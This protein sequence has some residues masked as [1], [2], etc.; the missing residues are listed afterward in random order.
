HVTGVQTC[1]L[2]IANA[3]LNDL[4]LAEIL[5]WRTDSKALPL[6][7]RLGGEIGQPLECLYKLGAT[8]GITR[9]I[10]RINANENITRTQHFSPPQCQGKE[11]RI[12]RRH[13]G[14]GD[15][16]NLLLR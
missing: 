6:D 7:T 1:A 2:P 4:S 11:Q 16:F 12:A 9:V 14:D 8:I 5:Q 15:A 13:I 3:L 10:D